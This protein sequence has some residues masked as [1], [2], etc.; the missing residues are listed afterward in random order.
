MA[1]FGIGEG[2]ALAS[3]AAT[4]VG[5]GVAVAGAESSAAAQSK[6]AAYSA[7]VA[8]NNAQIANQNASYAAQ[9]GQ[10]KATEQSLKSR[11]QVGAAIAGEA[12]QGVDVNSGSALDVQTTDREVG[13]LETQ[14][15]A[16]NAA[17]QVYGYRSQATGFSA[18]S[19]LDTAKAAN[20]LQAG[21]IS[22]TGDALSGAASVGEKYAKF[23]NSGALPADNSL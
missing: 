2:L 20:A 14:Q 23:Q 19:G 7:Q 9:A 5:T 22:A 8:A 11:A 4:T 3:I 17:L 21:D 13:K 15:V 10:E 16:N 1:D 18:D 6:S 12:A